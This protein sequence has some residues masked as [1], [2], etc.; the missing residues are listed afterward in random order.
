MKNYTEITFPVKS[1]YI[2][3]S[4]CTDCSRQY[5]WTSP[6][7]SFSD[8]CDQNRKRNQRKTEK[9][10]NTW[11]FF[12]RY[13]TSMNIVYKMFEKL[14]SEIVL[15]GKI[16]YE[17]VSKTN[18][19]KLKPS[20][21]TA[22]KMWKTLLNVIPEIVKTLV[23]AFCNMLWKTVLHLVILKHLISLLLRRHDEYCLQGACITFLQDCAERENYL[24]DCFKNK[25]W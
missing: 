24:W 7:Y 3:L 21:F 23:I 19:D 25:F 13:Y 1:D 4:K 20:S 14:F 5:C 8:N 10:L 15:K 9:N 17:I 18:F 11:Q 2:S 6:F 12:F 16:I 22:F